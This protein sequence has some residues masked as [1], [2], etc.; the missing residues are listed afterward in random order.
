MLNISGWGGV[1]WVV[2]GFV[3]QALFFARMLVQWI[4]SERRRESVVPIQFW[5]FSLLGGLMLFAYFIWR[6]D[7]V[8][9]LGQTTGVVV[10]ARNLRLIYRRR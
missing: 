2:L 5:W 10:Y 6:R 9:V 8:G 7:I 3:G 1:A 4:A